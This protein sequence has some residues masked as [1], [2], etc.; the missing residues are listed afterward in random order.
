[1]FIVIFLSFWKSSTEGLFWCSPIALTHEINAN[2]WYFWRDWWLFWSDLS[3]TAR[4]H[5][6]KF[7][8]CLRLHSEYACIYIAA[9][10]SSASHHA[11]VLICVIIVTYDSLS[12]AR[13]DLEV[14]PQVKSRFALSAAADAVS[15]SVVRPSGYKC[16]RQTYLTYIKPSKHAGRLSYCFPFHDLFCQEWTSR[17]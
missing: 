1:M 6:T 14:K 5:Q 10:C 16:L 15:L 8:L 9:C 11:I 17:I 4:L 13:S 7:R 2:P 12:A 3:L